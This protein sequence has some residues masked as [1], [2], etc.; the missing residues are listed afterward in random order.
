MTTNEPE[1]RMNMR[2]LGENYMSDMTI[3]REQKVGYT[4]CNDH[5]MRR[6]GE[7]SIEEMTIHATHTY[8]SQLCR[9]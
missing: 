2:R 5:N 3:N 7:N 6:L 1:W 9:D 8:P 4:F